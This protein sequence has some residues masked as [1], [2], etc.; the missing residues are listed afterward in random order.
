MP[1]APTAD[2][3]APLSSPRRLDTAEA[4]IELADVSFAYDTR[5]ILRGITMTVPR[6]KSSRSWVRA[7]PE[8]RRSCA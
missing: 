5:S 6:G 2:S 3:H 4:A 1:V 7:D 8:R